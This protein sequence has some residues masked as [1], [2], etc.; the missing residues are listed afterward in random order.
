MKEVL[1]PDFLAKERQSQLVLS[2]SDPM[3][4]SH[5]ILANDFGESYE[6]GVLHKPR[7][8]RVCH[9]HMLLHEAI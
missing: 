8:E 4:G 9:W 3:V 5:A 7:D 6:G 2:A 1:V